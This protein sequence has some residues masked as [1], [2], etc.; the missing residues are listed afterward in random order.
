MSSLFARIALGRDQPD[1]AES[2]EAAS[3][4]VKDVTR[5]SDIISRISLLFKKDV[6]Q[7]EL[8]DLNDVFRR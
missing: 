8:V 2:Q 3:R 7:R 4:L 6:L 5:A 1:V